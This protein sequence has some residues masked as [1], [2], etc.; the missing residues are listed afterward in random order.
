MDASP[1]LWNSCATCAQRRVLFL[2]CP[3]LGAHC[4]LHRTARADSK[5]ST[6]TR[7]FHNLIVCGLVRL[8]QSE[9]RVFAICIA[10]ARVC[11]ST[12]LALA[13]S[14]SLSLCSVCVCVCVRARQGGQRGVGGW[15]VAS[16][17]CVLASV[18]WGEHNAQC[19]LLLGMAFNISFLGAFSQ[20]V[21]GHASSS[22]SSVGSLPA[23]A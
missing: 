19:T 14:L 20:H 13:L 18:W 5:P 4:K 22:P 10:F 21:A 8:I 12:S 3:N 1:S 2:F 15:G 16:K 7:A 23:C 9:H 6:G 17:F 11:T